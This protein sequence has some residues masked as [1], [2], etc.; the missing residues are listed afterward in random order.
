MQSAGPTVK[1]V[2]YG[3]AL[4]GLIVSGGLYLH[5]SFLI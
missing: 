3:I 5:V 4:V 2:S 1:M